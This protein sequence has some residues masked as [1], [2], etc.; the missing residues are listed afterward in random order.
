MNPSTCAVVVTYNR[1][2]LLREC[3]QALL[4]QTRPPDRI[5]VV[6]NVSTDGTRE[7]LAAEF[8][9]STFPS[10]ELLPLPK[11][12]GGAGGFHAGMRRASAQGFD[13]IWVM[14]DDSIPQ[15]TALG[16][17]FA[18][19]ERFP[20]GQ[21][22]D[23]LA[24]K[25]VWTDGAMHPATT[26]RVKRNDFLES[27]CFAAE[28]ATLSLRVTSFV[29]V[30]IH[31][32]LVERY[33]LPIA[34]YFIWNDDVEYTARVLRQEF[35]VLVPTSVVVHKTAQ[36]RTEADPRRFYYAVRN[37]L[38]MTTRSRAWSGEEKLR[39]IGGLLWS[40]FTYLRRSPRSWAKVKAVA[41]GLFDGLFTAPKA[42][43]DL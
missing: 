5:L 27:L 29:S 9:P 36:R 14:D 32:R 42:P 24:S 37:Q 18:A 23:L 35:G 1:R 33:G 22:P 16:E 20:V 7:M 30:M 10:I 17:L 12:V 28:R 34:D 26:P 19:R 11:N 38:W 25:V 2:D 41:T 43:A 21:Q 13:W 8:A 40:I 3:L 31:R 6:D 4:A 15:P 39:I